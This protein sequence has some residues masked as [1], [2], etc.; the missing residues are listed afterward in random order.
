MSSRR[1]RAAVHECLLCISCAVL[2]V[3]WCGCGAERSRAPSLQVA[4]GAELAAEAPAVAEELS[5]GS[6]APIEPAA[7]D[8]L[9]Q[10]TA[11]PS[12]ASVL[13]STE[14]EEIAVDASA[15]GSAQPAASSVQ[16]HVGATDGLQTPVAP[17]AKVVVGGGKLI[18]VYYATDRLPTV[19]LI[20]STWRMFAP[21]GVVLMLC[22][23]LFIGYSAARRFLALWL[24]GC[25][26]AICL[27]VTVLHTAIIRWQQYTRLARN[28]D[29]RF[30]SVRDEAAKDYPLHLG[31]ARVSLPANHQP[32]RFEQPQVYRFEFVEREDR[33]I[34]LHSLREEKSAD[35][36]FGE[37]TAAADRSAGSE[38][39]VFVHGYNVRFID[40][41]KR[42]AQL[43]NDLELSG[44][45]ICYSWPSRGEVAG[46]AA[47]EASVSWSAP[48]FEQLL[49]DL[50]AR[51]DCQRVHVVAHSM[52]NRALLQAI[53][54][55]DMRYSA[56]S[57]AAVDAQ[58]ASYIIDSLVMAAP[59]VDLAEFASRYARP[60]ANRARRATLYFSD[61][62]R[63]LWLSAGLHGA[64]R[65]GLLR[66]HLHTFIGVESV[67]VG[68]QSS[69]SLGHSY[70]GDDPAV[71]ADLK[72]LL[73][74]GKTAA[75]RALIKRLAHSGSTAY[76]TLE[77][78]LRAHS[79][80]P[81]STLR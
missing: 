22:A 63:A 70:Y 45:A 52:G 6:L 57:S 43:S 1:G 9:P 23:A 37:L 54:R 26:L 33:H 72:A 44:P 59:D 34:V 12:H 18:E 42:T 39:F 24:V 21:A 38:I 51:T 65:L 56:T 76:W 31:A 71:I 36:W 49:L 35:V 32:G 28:A 8:E 69:L 47:D 46:Y 2:A 19:E 13:R 58:P 68:S 75:E 80:N 67:Y 53:E 61:S 5:D 73:R 25:A 78:K 79:P 14:E 64:P 16:H 41:L 7:A 3:G 40:A 66:D 81:Q 29:T 55:I 27:G 77:Q 60:L 15:G 17:A 20:P 50:R 4:Q 48:H 10:L 11:L 74:E 30:S 62:D